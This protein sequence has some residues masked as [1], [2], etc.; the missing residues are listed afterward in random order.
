VKLTQEQYYNI[1]KY[2]IIIPLSLAIIGYFVWFTA[3]TA[4]DVSFETFE[5]VHS[6]VVVG[7]NIHVNDSMTIAVSCDAGYNFELWDSK[8]NKLYDVDI[9]DFLICQ[10]SKKGS[11]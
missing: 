8:G 6:S 2:I 4:K 1:V 9:E 5:F 3:H 7:N 10:T 11:S